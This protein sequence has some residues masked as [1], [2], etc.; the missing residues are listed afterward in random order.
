MQHSSLHC[1]AL[2]T[3]DGWC[4]FVLVL[5]MQIF[6]TFWLGP[7]VPGRP[8]VGIHLIEM[9]GLVSEILCFV[10]NIVIDLFLVGWPGQ[11]WQP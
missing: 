1:R 11:A 5:L 4:C 7:G 2:C 10:I 9:L 3:L 8:G 6:C